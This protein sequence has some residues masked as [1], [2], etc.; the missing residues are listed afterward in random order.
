MLGADPVEAAALGLLK[1]RSLVQAC[2]LRGGSLVPDPVE[3]AAS[4]LLQL[5]SLAQHK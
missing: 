3:V 1:Q 5:R 2:S 4:G